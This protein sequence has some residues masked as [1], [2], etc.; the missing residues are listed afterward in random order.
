[1]TVFMLL[2]LNQ[3]VLFWVDGL[4]G[5]GEIQAG[6]WMPVVTGTLLWPLLAQALGMFRRHRSTR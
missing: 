4:T 2:T 5:S 3:F 6:R 1:M